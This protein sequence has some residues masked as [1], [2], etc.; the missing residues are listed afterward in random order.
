MSELHEKSEDASRSVDRQIAR[1]AERAIVMLEDQLE[2]FRER[3]T[4]PT[5]TG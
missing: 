4:P 1:I 5:W 2:W 3:G